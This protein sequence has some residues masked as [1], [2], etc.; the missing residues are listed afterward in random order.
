MAT[1][2]A[3]Y[4]HSLSAA[5]QPGGNSKYDRAIYGRP[6]GVGRPARPLADDCGY[7]S[8]G[9]GGFTQR[10]RRARAAGHRAGRPA[11]WRA[12]AVKWRAVLSFPREC[13]VGDTHAATAGTPRSQR[14]VHAPPSHIH[15][16]RQ[17]A[18]AAC[19]QRHAKR[20]AKYLM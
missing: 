9:T 15:M 20:F 14:V 13:S 10:T 19:V 11:G 12:P 2:A 3:A 1:A 7:R 5:G 16:R 8:S 4:F 18:R 17:H 6:E